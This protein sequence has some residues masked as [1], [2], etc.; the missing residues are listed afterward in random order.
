MRKGKGS[1]TKV[2]II[3]SELGWGQRV[4]EVKKFPTRE[5]AEKFVADFNKDNTADEAPDWYMVAR[6]VED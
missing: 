3:E 2:V 4:D 5:E 1:M 6:I